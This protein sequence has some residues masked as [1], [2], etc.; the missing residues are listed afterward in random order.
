MQLSCWWQASQAKQD[1]SSV[2]VLFGSEEDNGLA[3]SEV[4]A[5]K[6]HQDGLLVPNAVA[7][8]QPTSIDSV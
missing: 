1:L 4:A 6:G 5:A 7:L 3:A 8:Q 2:S